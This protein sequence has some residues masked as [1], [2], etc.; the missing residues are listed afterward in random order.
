M[1]FFKY[2]IIVMILI[3]LTGCSIDYNLYVTD[4]YIDE[5]I[6]INAED[7]SENI[8]DANKKY[9][10]LHY[11][12]D[13]EYNQTV[14]RK[15]GKIIVNLQYRYKFEEFKNANSFNQGFYNRNVSLDNNTININLSD[16]SGFAPNVNFDIKIK[17]KNEVI[18]SNA[19][20]V[21]GNTYIWHVD[22]NNKDK[23]KIDIKSKKDFILTLEAED[24]IVYLGECADLSTQML[25]IRKMIEKE[26]GIE[27]EFFINMDLNS[28]NPVFREKV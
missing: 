16:F 12:D 10:P 6:N 21:K 24:K 5:N 18:E 14:K 8:N 15:N 26:K 25:Y 3:I 22:G 28:S 20:I 19:D 11:S 2:L 7:N 9:N 27:G 23:L 17:T 1:K 4:N 13:I